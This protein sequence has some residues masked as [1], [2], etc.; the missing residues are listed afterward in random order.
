TA[1]FTATVTDGA[2]STTADL[3]GKGLVDGAITVKADV[4]D[5]A[6]NAATD[7]ENAT[8]DA[9]NADLPTIDLTTVGDGNISVDEA[10]EVT[11]SGT[12]TNVENGQTV[13]LTVTDSQGNTAQF[14]A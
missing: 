5:T 10:D 4:T 8:L 3:T 1:Q 13:T 9:D 2:F 7:S 12:T 6:G 11:L 14:T